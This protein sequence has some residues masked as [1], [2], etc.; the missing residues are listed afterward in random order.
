E[1]LKEQL[2]ARIWRVHRST[3][4]LELAATLAPQGFG[5][6]GTLELQTFEIIGC[7]IAGHVLPG[8]ARRVELLHARILV[9]A[10]GDEIFDVLIDEPVGTDQARDLIMIATAR[11]QL[12]RRGHVDAVDVGE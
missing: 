3:N 1:E 12:P 2:A 5:V 4:D 9:F 7:D 8:E 10:R 6:I 11:D